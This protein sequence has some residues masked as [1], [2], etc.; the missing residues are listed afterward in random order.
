VPGK[1]ISVLNMKGGVGKTT[2]SAHLMHQFFWHK[3]ISVL[4]I[5]LDPQ[6]NLTQTLVRP[7]E[8][9][10]AKARNE[11]ILT[12][13]EPP[14]KSNLLDVKVTNDPPPTAWELAPRLKTWS[15]E[16]FIDL[17]YGDFDLVK[18]SLISDQAKLAKVQ[19]R[20]LRFVSQAKEDYDLIVIDCN[21]S[22]S[23]ITQCALH[24]CQHV[25]V[26]VRAE[27]YSL[28]GLK[29]LSRYINEIPTIHPKPDISVLI[30]TSSIPAV[31]DITANELS[32]DPD[33]APLVLTNRFPY[34]LV[35][36]ARPN[37]FGF[38]LDQ[39]RR[40]N[41]NAIA[42]KLNVLVDELVISGGY[43]GDRPYRRLSAHDDQCRLARKEDY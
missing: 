39:K 24:A 31:T 21:P 11:T 3:E 14:P 43:D 29:L 18:Y 34:S 28:L 35:L 15:D 1:V 23:F 41:K 19:E 9:D 38:F 33:I 8:Y 36:A 26:P 30:N 25:L 2:V 13:M 10:A 22:S 32:G 17:V 6:F 4:L 42:Y 5:D 27:T 7:P 37:Q 20:F 12:A 40:P 16:C